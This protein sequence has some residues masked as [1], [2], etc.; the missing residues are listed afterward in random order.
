M[1]K[2]ST[3]SKLRSSLPLQDCSYKSS[4]C[5]E[6]TGT[7]FHLERENMEKGYCSVIHLS[8]FFLNKKLFY[9]K[10]EAEIYFFINNICF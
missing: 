4:F 10:V 1:T 3:A 9:Q 6:A 8:T 2:Y 5:S 7:H